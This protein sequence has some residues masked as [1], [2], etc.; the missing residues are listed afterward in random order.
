[1]LDQ[2]IVFSDSRYIDIFTVKHSCVLAAI[3]KRKHCAYIG[4]RIPP[5]KNNFPIKTKQS[6]GEYEN[7]DYAPRDICA[8][9][10]LICPRFSF[11]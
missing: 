3:A 11:A 6:D 4:Q 10:Q 5:L 7:T 8:F 9:P 1:M 2:F